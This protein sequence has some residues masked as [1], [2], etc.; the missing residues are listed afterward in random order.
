MH[1]EKALHGL[2]QAPH[3]WYEKMYAYLLAHGFQNSPTKSMLYVKCDNDV[4]LIVVVY[5]DDMLL[6]GP[7]ETHIANF[8]VDL[9]AAFEMSNMG[10]LHHYLGIWFTQIDGIMSLCQTKY[11]E[12]LLQHLGLEDYK[13]IATPMEPG[14]EL[15]SS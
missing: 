3:A 8:K 6:I 11:I 1:V 5:V 4:L 15:K 9:N 12:T 2:K 14:F 7:I 10:L 13:P